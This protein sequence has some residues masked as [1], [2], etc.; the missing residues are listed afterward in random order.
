MGCVVRRRRDGDRPPVPVVVIWTRR[1]SSAPA[2]PVTSASTTTRPVALVELSACPAGRSWCRYRRQSC[3]QRRPGDD[4]GDV[5]GA[6][7]TMRIWSPTRLR[8]PTGRLRWQ[9][10]TGRLSGGRR[11]E[12][13]GIPDACDARSTRVVRRVLRERRR[14]R[15]VLPSQRG[16]DRSRRGLD[17]RD[18]TVRTAEGLLLGR[19]VGSVVLPMPVVST[20]SPSR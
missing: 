12:Y 5:C 15:T 8:S 6:P 1:S 20:N 11:S 2:R 10:A 3:R 13:N 16:P 18:R 9:R 17:W 14:C 19:L 7:T 4:G